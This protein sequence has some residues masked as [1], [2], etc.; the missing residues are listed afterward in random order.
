MLK[1]TITY[2]DFN[3]VEQTE[4]FYFNLS[5][6]ELAEMEIIA[7]ADAAQ[8][9][10][11]VSNTQSTIGEQLKTIV[12]SGDGHEILRIFKDIV[13]RSYGIRSEDGA[14]FTKSKEATERFT[15]SGAMDALLLQFFADADVASAFVNG[16]IPAD[17]QDASAAAQATNGFRPGASTTP[18]T[19]PVVS[20]G[21]PP[22]DDVP[23]PVIPEAPVDT[24]PAAPVDT[25]PAAPVVADPTPAPA[26]GT[27]DPAPVT[28][29]VDVTPAPVTAP[30]NVVPTEVV[31]DPV[32]ATTP[33]DT[34]PSAPVEVA[35][36][37]TQAAAP[38]A[39]TPDVPSVQTELNDPSWPVDTAPAT[40]VD[41]APVS[42]DPADAVSIDPAPV[43]A[44]VD[45]TPAPVDASVTTDTDTISNPADQPVPATD[46]RLVTDLPA[47]VGG[48]DTTTD[49]NA[50]TG[51]PLFDQT[52]ADTAV[53]PPAVQN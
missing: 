32:P 17:L 21:T 50:V 44:P 33:V 51:S 15:G 19:P 6:R 45:V 2:T 34:T 38:V 41:D 18:P 1:Q 8:Q 3:D 24:T 46:P 39:V 43:T 29:P 40:V 12:A 30:V 37:P 11:E 28:A 7:Q 16:I 4:D 10:E 31:P 36:D 35:P 20:V 5:K 53:T 22:V 42:T 27:T 9:G 26:E 52:A 48:D 13:T 14:L 25:V 49:P 47:N 23:A